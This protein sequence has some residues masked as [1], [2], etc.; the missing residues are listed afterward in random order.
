[1]M[2]RTT[3][4]ARALLRTAREVHVERHGAKTFTPGTHLPL[5]PAAERLG[6]KPDGRRYGAAIEVL[7]ED[8]GAIELDESARYHVGNAQYL[9]TERGLE[10]LR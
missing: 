1:M 9:I 7:E 10:M 2:V 6:I 8:E 4:D 3:E 5:E